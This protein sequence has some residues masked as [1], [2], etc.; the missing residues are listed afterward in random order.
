MSTHLCAGGRRIIAPFAVI[1]LLP[2]ARTGRPVSIVPSRTA[3][4]HV[5]GP[6]NGVE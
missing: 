2:V 4:A 3:A 6:L 1:P 5:A